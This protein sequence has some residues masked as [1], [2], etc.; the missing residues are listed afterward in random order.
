MTQAE[1]LWQAYDE[2]GEPIADSGL[3]KPQARSGI[4]HGASHVWVWRRTRNEVEILLQK[5]AGGKHTWPGYYDISAA[6]HIDFGETPLQAAL[7]E[8]KEEIGLDVDNTQPRLLFVHRAN[9]VNTG[10][11]GVIENEFQW[12]YGLALEKETAFTHDSEVDL[13]VWMKLDG[14]KQLIDQKIPGKHIVP[15][16]EAYFANLFREISRSKTGQT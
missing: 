14:F 8:T 16:G 13:V 9:L 11:S 3:T 6:G 4:L 5:R 10:Q 2:Q 7:R 15:H 1:E 12:V